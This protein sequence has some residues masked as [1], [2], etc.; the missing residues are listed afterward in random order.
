MRRWVTIPKLF[1][2]VLIVGLVV[3][4]SG[5]SQ[6]VSS[7]EYQRVSNQLEEAQT[8]VSNLVN[9]NSSLKTENENL[10]A[11]V[12][13]LKQTVSSPSTPTTKTILITYSSMIGVT[14]LIVEPRQGNVYLMVNMTTE[15]QGYD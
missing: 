2:I 13:R 5:C 4:A 12:A 10:K 6:G 1:L 15:N 7:E 8:K 3:F 9:E 14:N 11:E